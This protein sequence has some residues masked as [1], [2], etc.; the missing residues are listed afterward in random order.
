M[1]NS[2]L[3]LEDAV[4]NNGHMWF[5]FMENVIMRLQ[6]MGRVG[7]SRAYAAT[8]RSFF[9]FC[10]GR[11]L[12]IS[13]FTQDLMEEYEAHLLRRGLCRNTTSMYMRVLRA[14]YNRAFEQHLAPVG[15]PFK[16]VY[17]GVDKTVK[18]A[19]SISIIKEIKA[20]DLAP[21]SA[22]AW[23]RDLFLFSFYTRGMSFIDMAYLKRSDLKGGSIT[24]ARHKT[25]RY[26]T[27][28]W[29]ECMAEIVRKYEE[30]T[31]YPYL[32]PII[33]HENG[34]ERRQYEY[35]LHVANRKLKVI[36]ELVGLNRPLSTYV[37][38]HS[39]ANAAKA[40]NIPLS[41]ICECMGHNSESTT[42]I[43]LSSIT[44]ETIDSANKVILMDL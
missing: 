15:N 7:T 35:A 31:R 40:K 16:H 9:R 42:Q 25:N 8:F 1:T 17:I 28:G 33:L 6:R 12:P 14:V 11:D 3:K 27:I 4:S 2:N 41:I 10:E 22:I 43:Y 44:P 23:A 24:Y 32:L 5:A 26:L 37:A 13:S 39:W 18:R 19:A 30:T 21:N 38:R 20:L 29:E 36:A 34:S